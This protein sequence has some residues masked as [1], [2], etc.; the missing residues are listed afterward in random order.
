MRKLKRKL[1]T[2]SAGIILSSG[3]ALVSIN[4]T[5]SNEHL[6][7]VF[8][9]DSTETS[10]T[11]GDL[12]AKRWVEEVFLTYTDY[13]C[14]GH[15]NEDNTEGITIVWEQILM[16]MW[17]KCTNEGKEY[18]KNYHVGDEGGDAI[19]DQFAS[20]YDHIVRKY[21]LEDFIGRGVSSAKSAN[22][23]ILQ[24]NQNEAYVVSAIA[25]V[26]LTSLG[27]FYFVKKNRKE[28]N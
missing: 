26:C 9:E 27:A 14:V 17:S 19:F 12:D 22:T 28:H 1:L 16:K 13:P 20:L 18:L 8:A 25:L 11:E 21:G 3:L 10:T 24:N 7:S 23:T 6:I 4:N 5:N 15:E 2:I